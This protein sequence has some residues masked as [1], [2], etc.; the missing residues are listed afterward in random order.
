MQGGKDN[1]VAGA[2]RSSSRGSA[3]TTTVA[4]DQGSISLWPKCESCSSAQTTTT[5]RECSRHSR[6]SVSSI[7]TLESQAEML[8]ILEGRHPA[9]ALL[10]QQQRKQQQQAQRGVQKEAS[11]ARAVAARAQLHE[12]WAATSQPLTLGVLS[13]LSGGASAL[14]NIAPAIASALAQEEWRGGAAALI[15]Q[16]AAAPAAVTPRVSSAARRRASTGAYG[17]AG[18]LTPMTQ[19]QPHSVSAS[20]T[21]RPPSSRDHRRHDATSVSRTTN[22]TS[23]L[24]D[25]RHDATS[26]SRTSSRT[27][28]LGDAEKACTCGYSSTVNDWIVNSSSPQG[29]PM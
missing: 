19:L 14:S 28:R 21:P 1:A 7:E 20:S 4:A 6:T 24:S 29:A 5:S 22:R 10:S 16:S 17:L 11:L 23:R 9:A 3:S 12:V 18:S 27:S 25:D 15:I 26:V 2:A 13:G 8:T